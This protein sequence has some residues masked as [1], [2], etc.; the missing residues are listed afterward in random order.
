M[1]NNIKKLILLLSLILIF[2]TSSCRIAKT[3]ELVLDD[4]ISYTNTSTDEFQIPASNN[5][6][7]FKITYDCNNDNI[8]ESTSTLDNKAINPGSPKKPCA[9]FKG[10][11]SDP[12]CETLYDFD[13]KVTSA[14]TLY[15]GWD[16]DIQDL[17]TTIYQTTIKSNVKVTS[18]P[19]TK[20]SKSSTVSQGSGIIFLEDD[21]KYYILTNNH[22]TYYD[23]NTYTGSIY[24]VTDCYGNQ[25]EATLINMNANYDL[26]ILTIRKELVPK[27]L[28]VTNICNN[29][30]KVNDLCLSL[31]N[32]ESL[33]NSIS[34]GKVL[35][36]QK[37]NP[38]SDTLELNN[39]SFNVIVN[40]SYISSGSSG[41]A[42]IDSNLKIAGIQFASG[43]N[44]QTGEFMR[45]YAVPATKV[46]QYIKSVLN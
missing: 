26:A 12:E 2:V 17:T 13:E 22:V 32:P 8:Y 7:G 20:F 33:M 34:Y 18:Q 29:D 1:K 9:T 46:V 10:W 45:A 38:D 28:L 27:T 11:F 6:N 19:H 37:F 24:I 41:G 4:T 42:L 25:Y 15:A 36:Y 35:S 30:I 16:I 5:P 14:L 43:N 23:K 39:V 3:D 44:N 40:N 21:T 31:G